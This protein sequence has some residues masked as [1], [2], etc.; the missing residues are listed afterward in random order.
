M[1]NKKT[2]LSI[3]AGLCLLSTGAGAGA[4]STGM[5]KT[6][7]QGQTETL[8]ILIA[9]DTFYAASSNMTICQVAF[10]EVSSGET[11]IYVTGVSP[12]KCTMFYFNNN[13][14]YGQRAFNVVS[15]NEN[16]F[17]LVPCYEFYQEEYVDHFYTT[18]EVLKN[19]LMNEL[20][21]YGY[22]YNGIAYYVYKKNN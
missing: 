1:L 3:T 19:S 12:G 13:I 10:E 16:E 17:T 22:T 2:L 4:E 14:L 18:D 11:L 21:H 20:K 15:H 7:E 6:I 5:T 8:S 9:S